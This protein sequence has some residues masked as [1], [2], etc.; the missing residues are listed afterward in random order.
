MKKVSFL[1]LGCKVNQY[2]SN[3]MAQKFI[4]AGYEICDVD[5]KPDIVIVNTCTVTNIAN[6]KSRQL[7]RKVKEENKEAIVVA[8][9]MLCSSCQRKNR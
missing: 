1:T 6:R 7:L 9:R 2:E 4:E 8:V 3:A 5:K